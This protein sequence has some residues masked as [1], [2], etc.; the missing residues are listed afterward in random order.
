MR[1]KV[2]AV[3]AVACCSQIA[4]AQEDGPPTQ[5]DYD[6]P[7]I[8]VDCLVKRIDGSPTGSESVSQEHVTIKIDQTDTTWSIYPKG[9]N[10]DTV[11]D[12]GGYSPNEDFPWTFT[13]NEYPVA[14]H[15]LYRQSYFHAMT[16]AQNV[17]HISY[18]RCEP[19]PRSRMGAE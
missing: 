2:I 18:G 14:P 19:Q 8:F 17:M 4:T 15:V 9:E 1:A 7:V 12:N 3:V 16:D 5:I 11:I 13:F 6:Q 10:G